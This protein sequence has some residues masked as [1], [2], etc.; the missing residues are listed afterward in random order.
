[1]RYF[2][3]QDNTVLN[4]IGAKGVRSTRFISI[5]AGTSGT[6]TLPSSSTVVLDDFG[7]TVD[8]V[9]L[10]I[11]GGKPLAL[12]ALTAAGV[13]VATTFDASGNWAFSGTPVSYPVAIV[14]RVKQSLTDFDSTSADI[15]GDGE[16][17]GVLPVADGGTGLS[18]FTV[19]DITYASATNVLSALAANATA[20]KKFLSMTSS[21]PAWGQPA[22]TDISGVAAAAQIPILSPVNGSYAT[23]IA[24]TGSQDGQVFLDTTHKATWQWITDEWDL[25][26]VPQRYGFDI[27]DE[28]IGYNNASQLGWTSTG[29]GNLG[30]NLARPGVWYVE[31]STVSTRAFINTYVAGIA[32]GSGDFFLEADIQIPVLSTGAQEFITTW[33]FNDNSAFD[34]GGNCTDGIFFK[35]DRVTNGANWITNTTS[36]G[37]NTATNTST[38]VV[39]G[40]WYRLKVEVSTTN[41]NAKFYV[42]G[43]LVATHTLTIPSGSARQSGIQ[44]KID[45]T[46]GNNAVDAYI[47]YMR[48]YGFTNGT[49]RY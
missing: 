8:A 44:L 12:P 33:G 29:A 17:I 28:F 26:H 48:C 4:A 42:N 35:L 13:V 41:S 34:S 30:N 19:G 5:G 31:P 25:L 22:F 40:T 24:L 16:I 6:L 9:V 49:S 18:T 37:S 46:V 20:T 15:W 43:T 21:V 10:Q 32:F 23:M 14:Y 3:A 1:M 45:K 11:S 2:P 47:D 7:G 27:K 36:N 39:A 38:A